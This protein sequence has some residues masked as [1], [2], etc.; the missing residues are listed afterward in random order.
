MMRFLVNEDEFLYLSMA[1]AVN[2]YICCDDI[3]LIFK[4]NY[5]IYILHI[6]RVPLKTT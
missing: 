4:F 2:T 5:Y 1:Y 3:S 6:K